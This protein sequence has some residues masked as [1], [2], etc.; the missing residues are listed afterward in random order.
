M[1][2]AV[3]NGQI[4][5]LASWDVKRARLAAAFEL[6][7]TRGY[8]QRSAY[9]AVRDPVRHRFQYQDM[10]YRGADLLGAGL[11]SFSYMAGVHYQNVASLREYQEILQ[12][13][14]LPYHRAY[15]LSDEEQMVREFVLQLKL[16]TI[17]AAYFADKFQVNV[18]ARFSDGLQKFS[19]QGWLTFDDDRITM[20][21]QGLLRV[22]RLLP[23]FYLSEHRDL[24]YW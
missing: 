19:D 16:G 2:R 15:C 12:D 11:A 3:R 14:R 17:D 7:D 1:F 5:S 20:T 4:D 13:D 9:A 8:T 21:R 22:D 10:Q 6:L 23:E 24:T 18:P